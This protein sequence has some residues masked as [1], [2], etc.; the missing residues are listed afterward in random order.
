MVAE[1]KKSYREIKL[2]ERI[3]IT[4]GPD[5]WKLF[6][7][8]SEGHRSTLHNHQVIFSLSEP[9]FD[10]QGGRI[11]NEA[12]VDIYCLRR[13]KDKDIH[14]FEGV[15]LSFRIFGYI[16]RGEYNPTTH[17]GYLEIVKN[18]M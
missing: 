16:L 7:S 14:E 5:L 2:G 8:Y 12:K 17:T 15:C 4:D 18:Y 11:V 13:T 10:R 1:Q 6:V 3:Q 9:I